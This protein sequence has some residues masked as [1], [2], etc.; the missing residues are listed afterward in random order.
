MKQKST[1]TGNC[2]V[3]V[4]TNSA[5]VTL[6]NVPC[7]G[8]DR[9]PTHRWIASQCSWPRLE[10]RRII[11]I[12]GSSLRPVKELSCPASKLCTWTREFS[13]LTL[14]MD[15]RVLSLVLRQNSAHGE[16]A[17]VLRDSPRTALLARFRMEV[18]L[19][20]QPF[21]ARTIA[22]RSALAPRSALLLGG[23]LVELDYSTIPASI[24]A[25]ARR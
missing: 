22:T 8:K 20:P 19:R 2:E 4:D 7:N 11:M 12:N 14:H 25:L 6:K 16:L 24:V 1:R 18:R 3:T 17:R 15:N 10:V 5:F 9:S 21:G 13:L 23:R